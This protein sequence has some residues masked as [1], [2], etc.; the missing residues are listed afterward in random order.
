MDQKL[1]AWVGNN[2]RGYVQ[3][4]LE[5]FITLRWYS[6]IIGNYCEIEVPPNGVMGFIRD[7]EILE[8][9]ELEWE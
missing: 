6:D 7:Q 9:G 8:G 1:P 3:W 4:P 5:D 2:E